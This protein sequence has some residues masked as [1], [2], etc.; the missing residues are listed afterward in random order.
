VEEGSGR[1]GLRIGHDAAMTADGELPSAADG[2][3]RAAWHLACLSRSLGQRPL[4]RLM[5]GH[6]VVLF[7]DEEGRAAALLDRC[8]HRNAPLSAGWRERDGDGRALLRCRYHGWSFDAEG[9]C[10]E[11]PGLDAG[12]GPAGASGRVP[13]V[14]VPS[15]PV[16]ER[17][18]LV[19]AWTEPGGE[20]QGEPLRLPAEGDPRYATLVHESLLRAPLDAA[21]ENVL[22]V[23]HTSFLHG[24][25]FRSSRERNDVE[26]IV[27]RGRDRVEAEYVGEPRPSGLLGRLLAPGGGG[28]RHVDRF[29][30]PATA[31]VEYAVGEHGHLVITS[32]LTPEDGQFGGWMLI[33]TA[34]RPSDGAT[35]TAV[36]EFDLTI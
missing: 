31:Q 25:V 11:V 13:D 10:R 5:P 28:V 6:P 18:G 14:R 8:P 19:F 23:P 21:L 2:P 35:R 32:F 24:G 20:P 36:V 27:R 16:V 17:D 15:L 33:L 26:A 34:F 12:R 9:R 30:L 29:L 1:G 22:D 3:P 4:R 7:R